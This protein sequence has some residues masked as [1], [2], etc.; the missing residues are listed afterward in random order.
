MIAEHTMVVL[1]RDIPEHGLVTGDVGAVVHVYSQG[2]A[3][4]VEFVD[5]V[6]KTVALLTLEATVLRTI[7]SGELLHTRVAN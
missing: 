4:E 1:N 5:G 3:Y 6:G 7:Q 2:T